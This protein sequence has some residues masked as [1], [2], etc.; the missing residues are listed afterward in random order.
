VNPDPEINKDPFFTATC[1]GGRLLLV[2]YSEGRDLGLIHTMFQ[3]E[4]TTSPLG[5]DF[6]KFTLEKLRAQKQE[7]I[8]APNS[9]D[10]TIFLKEDMEDKKDGEDSK[11]FIGEIGLVNWDYETHVVEIFTA[12]S[13]DYGGHGY[14]TEAVSVLME[15]IFARSMISGVR[16]QTLSTNITALK[17]CSRLGFRETGRRAVPFD[18]EIGF[19]GGIAVMLDC[20]MHE[21]TPWMK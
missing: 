11:T 19:T 15:R 1:Q 4:R 12:L 10:W 20:R 18:P 16:M 17:L 14:G 9:G 3:D 8:D 6:K 21:F 5:V 2:P 7:R 13:G